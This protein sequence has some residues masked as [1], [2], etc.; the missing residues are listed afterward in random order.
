MSPQVKTK[1]GPLPKRI[2]KGTREVHSSRRVWE[3]SPGQIFNIKLVRI[4]LVA[5]C[6]S[7][8]NY[9]VIELASCYAQE[10]RYNNKLSLIDFTTL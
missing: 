6:A 5:I 2:V 8:Y 3:S 9:H 1:H 7:K 10:S 4:A